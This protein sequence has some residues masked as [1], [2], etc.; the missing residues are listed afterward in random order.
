M[1]RPSIVA[2]SPALGMALSGLSVSASI[3]STVS[4]A[5]LGPAEQLTPITSTGHSPKLRVKVSVLAP[6][7]KRPSSSTVTCAIMTMSGPAAS[8]AA[9]I[10]SRSSFSSKKVS[11]TIRSTPAFTSASACSRNTARASA[12]D[13]GPSGSIC[14][15]KGPIAPATKARSPAASR[16]RRTPAS[17]IAGSFSANPNALNRTRLLPKVFVSRTSAPART[18]S[19]WISRTS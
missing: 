7:R 3:F 13:M 15:P 8:R 9:K 14:T 17:T 6:S 18:Y 11:S 4:S 12:K 10:A 5:T 19:W 1:L 2:G 16:A